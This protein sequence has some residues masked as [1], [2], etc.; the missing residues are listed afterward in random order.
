MLKLMKFK[1]TWCSPCSALAKVIDKIKPNFSDVLFEEID[2]DEEPDL[3]QQMNVRAVPTM[4]FVKDGQ[5]VE[6]MVG[7]Q[8][9]QAIVDTINKWR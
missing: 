2:I 8:K 7:L 3:A 9:E 6:T 1:G 5:V 4:V